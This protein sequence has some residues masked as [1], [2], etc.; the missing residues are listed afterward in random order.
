MLRGRNVGRLTAIAYRTFFIKNSATTSG[1]YSVDHTGFI[2]LVGKDGKYVGFLPPGVTPDVI[3]DAI[4]ARLG[5][6]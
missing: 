4:R 1:E 3:A 5:P 6:E 2:Y